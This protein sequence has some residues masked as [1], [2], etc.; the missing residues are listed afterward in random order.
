MEFKLRAILLVVGMLI[1]VIVGFDFFRRKPKYVASNAADKSR[2]NN[3][4]FEP[5]IDFTAMTEFTVS[6]AA[7]ET[8]T[9]LVLEPVTELYTDVADPAELYVAPQVIA[10]TIQA[11]EANGFQSEELAKALHAAQIFFGNGNIFYRY[12]DD[13]DANEVLF[14]VVKAIEPGYFAAE[15]LANEYIPGIT[16]LLLPERVSNFN[17]AFDKFVRA[18]KQIAFAVNGELLDEQRQPLTLTTL[19]K[20]RQ[21]GPRV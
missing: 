6:N 12:V 21:Q 19:A 15:T 10:I 2:E 9:E 13:L 4:I 1:L 11:R 3:K 17:V 20:Y 18:A 7:P 8:P 16:L 5:N 14:R